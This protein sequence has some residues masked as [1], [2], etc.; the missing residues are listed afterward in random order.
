MFW[1]QLYLT[2]NLF[3]LKILCSLCFLGKY[4]YTKFKNLLPTLVVI[5]LL[6][7]GLNQIIF[8]FLCSLLVLISILSFFG[9]IYS[10]DAWYPNFF[11]ACSYSGF[12][13]SKICLLE[14]FLE[15]N[16]LIDVGNLFKISSY[17]PP[18]I[19]KKITN[20]NQRITFKIVGAKQ[21][22]VWAI[23]CLSFKQFTVWAV[24]S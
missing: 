5:L 23:Y 7:D 2:F 17:H 9:S 15:S 13:E 20:I 21:L 22:T 12:T 3:L 10:S 6:N 16:L 14:G 19:F 11:S 18:E 8:R 24:Y 1:P 4:F